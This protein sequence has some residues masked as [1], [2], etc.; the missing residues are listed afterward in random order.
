[1]E[2]KFKVG[3]KFLVGAK[4]VQVEVI[5]VR[6]VAKKRYTYYIRWSSAQEVSEWDE[7]I[8]LRHLKA[9]TWK[10]PHGYQTPLWKVLNGESIE[11]E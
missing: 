10:H 7:N 8:V 6:L 2:S 4:L 9:G 11:D 5:K 1:M 3:D